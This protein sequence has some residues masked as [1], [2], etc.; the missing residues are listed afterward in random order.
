MSVSTHLCGLIWAYL[1]CPAPPE[2]LAAQHHDTEKTHSPVPDACP[3]W[4]SQLVGH[5][6]PHE[7]IHLHYSGAQIHV[8]IAVTVVPVTMIWI[9]VP[10]GLLWRWIIVVKHW[11]RPRR[12]ACS[13]PS[14]G[15]VIL[16]YYN[17]RRAESVPCFSFIMFCVCCELSVWVQCAIN[18]TRR[19]ACP[20]WEIA[21]LSFL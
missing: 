6:Q 1:F 5:T 12:P 20:K 2:K 9:T 10:F 4:H 13:S 14:H 11:T 18:G 15:T 7:D 21:I 16:L 19:S 17:C 8:W 3:P